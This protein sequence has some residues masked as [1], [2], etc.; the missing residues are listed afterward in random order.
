MNESTCVADHVSAVLTGLDGQPVYRNNMQIV[1]RVEVVLAGPDGKVKGRCVV[2]NLV[3]AVG[4]QLYASRGA[5]LT[6]SAVP[7]GMKLGTGSTAVAK[8]GAGSAL[9][10]YL[11]G[12][13]KA[14]DATFPSATGG[15]ASYKRTYAAGE[16]TTASPI[17]E[18]AIVTETISNDDTST[19]AETVSRA[20][21][22]GIGSK[23][24]SDTLTITWTHTILGA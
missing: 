22:T 3:T 5:G 13:N 18:C 21:L 10:T 20:L 8:S 14:F 19:E 2:E 24:A 17:T 11:S 4:D 6:S 15:V 1:G 16:A 12:S 9:T 23:G 7:T